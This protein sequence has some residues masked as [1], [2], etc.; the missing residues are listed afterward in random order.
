MDSTERGRGGRPRAQAARD[1]LSELPSPAGGA[2]ASSPE[3]GWERGVTQGFKVTDAQVPSLSF[4]PFQ[5][6]NSTNRNQK[7]VNGPVL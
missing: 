5:T 3:K 1:A 2:A 6:K 7:L 4:F